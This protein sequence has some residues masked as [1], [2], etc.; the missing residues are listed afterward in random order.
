VEIDRRKRPPIEKVVDMLNGLS[1][2]GSS[3]LLSL[4][5]QRINFPVK[6]KRLTSSSLYLINR[7]DDRIA[8]RLITKTPRRYRT[9]LPICSIVLPKCTCTLNVI[10]PEQKKASPLDIDDSLTLQTSKIARNEDLEDVD[11]ASV[12]VFLDAAGD[13]VQEVKVVV[14]CEP[15][16]ETA[17]NQIIDGQNY[18]EV[19]SVDVHPTKPWILT[20]NKKGYVCIWNH[21]TQE[22]V[23]SIEVTREPVYSVKFIEREE[24]FVVGTGDGCISVYNY[25][26][27]EEVVD[28]IEAH[29]S[30]GIMCLA[31]NPTH[32]YVL[33]AS[34]DHTIKIWDWT[35]EW[36]CIGT[37][38]GHN[39][40]VTQV[41]FDPRNSESFASASLDQTIKIW[42]I[43]SE[44]CNITWDGHPEGLLCLHYHPRYFEQFLI[45]GSS[46]GDAK[47]WDLDTDTCV[48]T[49]QGHGDGLKALCWHPELRVLVTGSLDGTVRIW[50]WKSTSSTYRLEN[51]IR[52]NLGAINALGY[53]KGSTRIVVGCDQG[54]ALME[55]NV[56]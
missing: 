26:T 29:D 1:Q 56:M 37:F 32:S 43:R 34:D 40:T 31:V 50:N 10:T 38:E 46:D 48:D 11:P 15:L 24:W 51:I 44:T 16:P 33:S 39:H 7:T 21:Q 42:N 47:V 41:M 8:F 54:I 52:L 17:S 35:K 23:D 2:I 36:Q 20:S 3:S 45:S 4:Q 30:H 5:L 55:I 6:P 25:N 13:E 27:M 28:P 53:L 19:L 18:R 14:A 49:L 22:E 9:K 12:A